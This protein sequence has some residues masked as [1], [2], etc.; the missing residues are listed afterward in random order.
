MTLQTKIMSA[1]TTIVLLSAAFIY[2]YFPAQTEKTL[3]EN[4]DRNTAFLAEAIHMAVDIAITAQEYDAIDKAFEFAWRN[5]ATQ[6]VVIFDGGEVFVARDREGQAFEW[7]AEAEEDRRDLVIRR[8]PLSEGGM[9]TL[10]ASSTD[11]I[12]ERIGAAERSAL[13]LAL[14]MVLI[15]I[16]ASWV[17]A[18]Q[19]N[20]PIG[21]LARAATAVGQGDFSQKVEIRSRDALGTLSREFASMSEQIQGILVQ[22]EE[23]KATVEQKVKDAIADA[24]RQKAEAIHQKE[25][26]RKIADEAQEARRQIEQQESYLSSSVDRILGEV[27]KFGHGDLRMSLASDS[28]D[29]VGRLIRGFGSANENLREVVRHLLSVSGNV[30]HSSRE[31]GEVST[32]LAENAD[33]SST[34]ATSASSAIEEIN[35][36]LQTV[37]NASREMTVSIREIS[38]N[39]ARASSVAN[40][41]VQVAGETDS[42]IRSLGESSSEIGEVV[43]LIQNISAQTN[44]LALNATIE[45]ARAGEAGKGFAVVANE[46]KELAKE[47]GKATEYITEKVAQI[48][49]GTEQA[50]TAISRIN[51]IISSINEIQSSIAA[52]IEEQSVTTSEIVNSVDHAAQSSRNIVASIQELSGVTEQTVTW[53]GNTSQLSSGLEQVTSSLKQITD[54]FQV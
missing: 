34:Q 21:R 8:G 37:S 20:T 27:E 49:S 24:E 41:A 9:Q 1:V 5:P 16:V 31:L 30:G 36:S 35:Q 50:G 4:F 13:V 53:A 7:N 46:V 15:G 45:A 25:L 3:R 28:E 52:A 38:Q 12:Q 26:A 44:L 2:N 47:T 42:T 40:Q 39:A 23:E 17:L 14:A 18:R 51:E 48:Q 11:L 54:R 22:L 29:S 19:V 33:L 43:Q 32:R 6:Y 10:V